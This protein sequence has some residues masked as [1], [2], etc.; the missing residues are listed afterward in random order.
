MGLAFAIGAALLVAAAWI[1]PVAEGARARREGHWDLALKQYAAAEARFDAWPVTK[2]V[3]P[4]AY[5]ISQANQL[6]VLYRLQKD[7]DLVEK[8]GA[9]APSADTHF[10]AGC[11]LFRKAR[12]EEQTEARIGWL[13]R[14]DEEFRRALELDPPDWDTK[15]NYELTRRLLAELKK[16]PKTP[17]NQLL[18]LLRPK[19]KAG[20]Q[21]TR[22]VG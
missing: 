1:R 4:G 18:Q 7:D 16:Q 15:Y 21:P 3:V 13:S 6:W 12:A 8:A 9:S 2:Q 20:G 19:P 17:P 10:W 11:A 5:R 14:A 22:R